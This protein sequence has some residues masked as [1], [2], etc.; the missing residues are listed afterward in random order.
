[1]FRIFLQSYARFARLV[2]YSFFRS[3]GTLGELGLRRFVLLCFVVPLLFVSQSVHWLCFLA[4]EILFSA[5]RKVKVREPL[6]IVGVPR[7]GTTF[8]HRLLS[9]DEGRFTTMTLGEIYLAPSILERRI[10]QGLGR[11]DAAL[12]GFGRAAVESLDRR[13]FRNLRNLHPQSLFLP[14]ED[15]QVLF[16]TFHSASLALLFPFESEMAHLMRF[17][18]AARPA[19]R[20]DVMI[21]YRRMVQRHLYVHGPDKRYLSKSP[22]FSVKLRSIRETFPDV[23]VVCNVRSPYE[24][25]PSMASLGKFY[26]DTFGNRL[27]EHEYR[28]QFL[29][30]SHSFYQGPMRVLPEWPEDQCAVLPYAELVAQPRACVEA[31]YARFGWP[32]S[33]EFREFLAGQERREQRYK[34]KHVYSMEEHGISHALLLDHMRDVFDFYGFPTH[35]DAA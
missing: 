24:C 11:V 33:G 29:E 26:W 12:G 18:E 16:P 1:M 17:D 10:F 31:I 28:R 22:A 9:G 7:S 2:F 8:F 4:D 30:I 20:R 23:R 13:F 6:F 15:D 3:R 5:Y 35:P 32:V 21:F 27:Y 14:D 25:I 34:S 19:L